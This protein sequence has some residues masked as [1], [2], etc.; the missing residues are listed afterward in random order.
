MSLRVAKKGA[1]ILTILF[2]FK[3]EKYSDAAFNY[4]ILNLGEEKKTS[5]THP[6]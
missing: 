2:F 5:K 4:P 6:S 3:I 1:E